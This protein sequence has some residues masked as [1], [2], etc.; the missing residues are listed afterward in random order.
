MISSTCKACSGV[1]S[2]GLPVARLSAA[3]EARAAESRVAYLTGAPAWFWDAD[4]SGGGVTLDMGCHAFEFFRW[5]LGK[6]Y[7]RQR[8][9][10]T[11]GGV[12]TQSHEEQPSTIVP[13]RKPRALSVYADILSAHRSDC[14]PQ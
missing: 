2:N 3:R 4:R 12:Q 6:P 11:A 13:L 7:G 1:T 5:L 10:G 14:V 8:G 9:T